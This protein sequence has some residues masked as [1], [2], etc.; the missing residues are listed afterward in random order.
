MGFFDVLKNLADGKPP[1]EVPPEDGRA[2]NANQQHQP[3]QHKEDK[4]FQGPK[5]IPEVEIERTVSKVDSGKGVQVQCIIQNNSDGTIELD[6]IRLL[7]TT[8]ELDIFLKPGEERECTVYQGPRPTNMNHH[9]AELCYKDQ[10][11]DYF[12]ADH[13]IEYDDEG[14]GTFILTDM[15]LRRPIRDI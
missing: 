10:T 2:V 5:V 1:F 14:D 13:Q 3:E 15:N 6:K 4:M 7:G 11:G 8:R 12:C 9:V